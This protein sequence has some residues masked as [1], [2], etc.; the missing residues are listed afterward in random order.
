[1]DKHAWARI[2]HYNSDFFFHIRLIAVDDAFA[3]S[4][5]FILKGTFVKAHEGVFLELSAF[6]AYFAFR[7]VV[8]FAVDLNHVSYGFLFTFHSFV[9]RVWGL[10]LHVYPSL[11]KT[12]LLLF[13]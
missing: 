4:A 8:V 3:A 2:P 5:F 9:F 10:R 12:I 1:M 11:Q 6:R 7:A 13:T